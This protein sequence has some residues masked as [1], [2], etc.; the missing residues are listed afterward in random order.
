ML[1]FFEF[2]ILFQ[3]I[4]YK[5]NFQIKTSA[6]PTFTLGEKLINDSENSLIHCMCKVCNNMSNN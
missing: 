2:V 5:N 1:I 4:I 6:Q 3:N